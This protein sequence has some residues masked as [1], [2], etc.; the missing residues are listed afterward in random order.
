[1]IRDIRVVQDH[2]W[3]KTETGGTVWA[4]TNYWLEVLRDGEQSWEPLMIRYINREPSLIE[5][6]DGDPI[7][8]GMAER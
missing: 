7:S 5:A 6:T 4:P 8:A 1:M 2:G 3:V